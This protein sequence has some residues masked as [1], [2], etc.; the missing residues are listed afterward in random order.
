MVEPYFN[1]SHGLGMEGL[2]NYANI[3][4]GGWFVNAFLAFIWIV[5]VYV[6]SK[7]DWKLP[8]VLSYAFFVTLLTAIIMKLFMSVSEYVIFILAVGLAISV[9]FGIATNR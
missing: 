1:S 2:L 3:L 4:T 8:G 6:M 7:S 5:M 9:G